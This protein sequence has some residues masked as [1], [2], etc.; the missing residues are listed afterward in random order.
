MNTENDHVEIVNRKHLRKIKPKKEGM[1]FRLVV[2]FFPGEMD[3]NEDKFYD[4]VE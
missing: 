2:V 4:E 3:M 1:E